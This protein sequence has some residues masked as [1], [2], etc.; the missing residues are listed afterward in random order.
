MSKLIEVP[1]DAVDPN[2]Y[3]SLNAYA[4]DQIK[5]DTLKRSYD[6]VGMWE[7]VIAR[8]VGNRYQ[9]AFGHHRLEAAKQN[10]IKKIPLIV[11]DVTDKRMIEYLGRENMEDYNANFEVMYDAWEAAVEFCR[12]FNGGKSDVLDIAKL[13]GWIRLRKPDKKNPK[14]RLI[15][16]EVAMACSNVHDLIASG[17]ATK[18]T[19]KGN[20]VTEVE[21][22]TRTAKKDIETSPRRPTVP[23]RMWTSPSRR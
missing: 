14:A 7:G 16:S 19:Y 6:D 21:V 13:L 3:R 5:V 20:S 9:I 1:V 2:P 8:Q 22:L 4:Y 10:K 23:R 12:R 17:D 15:S 11:K 18:D